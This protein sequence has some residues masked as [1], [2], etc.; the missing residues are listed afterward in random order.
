MLGNVVALATNATTYLPTAIEGVDFQQVLSEI[1]AVAPSILPVTV[2][3]L[4]FRKGISFIYST[5]RGA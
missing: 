5:L 2:A 3:C 4:A 1:T